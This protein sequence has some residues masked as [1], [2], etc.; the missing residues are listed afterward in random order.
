M[1]AI[2]QMHFGVLTRGFKSRTGSV[3]YITV[4]YNGCVDKE[5]LL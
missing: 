3:L 1:T 4:Y 5:D 2:N